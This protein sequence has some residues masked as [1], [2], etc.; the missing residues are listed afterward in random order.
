VNGLR[1]LTP[2]WL[3]VLTL[4]AIGAVVRFV[5]LDHQSFWVDETI[6][7]QLVAKPLVGMLQALPGAPRTVAEPKT[8]HRRTAPGSRRRGGS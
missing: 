7:A 8:I 3:V 2:T 6:T 1:V 5:G 4:T